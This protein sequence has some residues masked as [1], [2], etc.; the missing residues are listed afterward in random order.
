[1]LSLM[2]LSS[3]C[4]D[5]GSMI[6]PELTPVVAGPDS[7]SFIRDIKPIFD[8]AGC[9]SCH[10][11]NGGLYVSTVALI[12]QGGIHGPA[13][14]PGDAANS[15]LAQKISATPP[16]GDRMPQGGPYLPDSVQQVIRQWIN[17]GA[18]DN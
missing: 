13:V 18:L 1:V 2:Y 4:M 15:I 7:V 6:T 5:E 12:R 9:T 11:G 10:G 8:R 14:I 3:G 17:Q 16:F